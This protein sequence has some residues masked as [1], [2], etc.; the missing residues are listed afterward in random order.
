M[1]PSELEHLHSALTSQGAMIGCHEQL[2]QGISESLQALTMAIQHQATTASA[3]GAP[4]SC[5]ILFEGP[6]LFVFT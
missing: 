2:L 4:L 3:Q 6:R 1:D 5:M